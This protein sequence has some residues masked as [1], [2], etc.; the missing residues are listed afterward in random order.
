[1]SLAEGGGVS[2]VPSATF[3]SPF[4]GEKIRSPRHCTEMT[5]NIGGSAEVF[6]SLTG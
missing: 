5:E 2:S 3:A 1:M 6:E 4:K